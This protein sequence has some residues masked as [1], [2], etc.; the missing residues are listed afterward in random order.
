MNNQIHQEFSHKMLKVI[1]EFPIE[2]LSSFDYLP[3]VFLSYVTFM[4]IYL[5]VAPL[6]SNVISKVYPTLKLNHKIEWN[7]RFT[8]TILSLVVSSI[9]L[10]V[11]VVDHAIALSPLIYNSLLVKTNIAIVMG[12]T[13]SDMTIIL[14]N[15]KII[16]DVFT[17]LHHSFS[18]IGY[19]YALTYS[20]MPY[21]ANFR[22]ICELSTPLVNMRW[23]LYA[24]GLNKTSFYFLLNGLVMT[25]MFFTVRIAIIP[26]YWYKVYSV[27]DSQLWTQMQHFRYIMIITCLILDVINIFWFK[28][29]FRG[30]LIV[31]SSNWKN[32]KKNNPDEHSK[33][34]SS[35]QESFQ[36]RDYS[37]N[38]LDS[39]TNNEA[40][41]IKSF[42]KVD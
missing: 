13:L 23:F 18:L 31:A 29:M 1:P 24:S 9:S 11:L 41:Y 28:K 15:Y 32:Y 4:I 6:L 14:F 27:S 25:A 12:Y 21:F 16:G 19:G 33:I 3:I 5:V 30:A 42:K 26:I 37:E 35:Y 22:L 39:A 34:I 8:S 7:N 20:V 38:I 40:D 36:K 17:L 2:F 10:Y